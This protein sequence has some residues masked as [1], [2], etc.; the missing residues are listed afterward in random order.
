MG[1]GG[2]RETSY[3]IPH[4]SFAREGFHVG[5]G[6]LLQHARGGAVP[7]ARLEDGGD[8]TGLVAGEWAG[9]TQWDGWGV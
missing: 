1:K 2:I 8:G 9:P 3:R 6:E 5:D 4:L 7:C